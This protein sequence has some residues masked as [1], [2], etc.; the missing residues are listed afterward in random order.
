MNH[1]QVKGCRDEHAAKGYC[2]KHYARFKRWGNASIVNP[3]GRNPVFLKKKRCARCKK[4][5]AAHAFHPFRVKGKRGIRQNLQA[6]CKTCRNDY[7]RDWSKLMRKEIIRQYGNRCQ[8]CGEEKQEFLSI[9]HVN[10]G[11]R[12][13]R[14]KLLK[15]KRSTTMYI[16]LKHH[17]Y[18]K[19]KYRLLCMNCNWS[20]GRWRYCPHERQR[21]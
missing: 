15:M 19:D 10:G 9:D 13:H 14:H 12:T 3:P 8:C 18:P 20:L 7:R 4:T 5:K 2:H 6:Y 16:W 21:K 1:C 17:G 11:G